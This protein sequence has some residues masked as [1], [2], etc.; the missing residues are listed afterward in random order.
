MNALTDTKQKPW[1]IVHFNLLLEWA[2]RAVINLKKNPNINQL[3]RKERSTARRDK[4][5]QG[6]VNTSVRKPT[7]G[8]G[9]CEYMAD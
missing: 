4:A 8:R 7:G 1:C 3:G 6:L 9:Q 5:G 2:S